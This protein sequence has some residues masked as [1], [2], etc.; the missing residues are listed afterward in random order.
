MGNRRFMLALLPAIFLNRGG[1][2][3]WSSEQFSQQYYRIHQNSEDSEL[4]RLINNNYL[5]TNEPRLS[6]YDE[7]PVNYLGFLLMEM[8]EESDRDN[9][10]EESLD[11]VFSEEIGNRRVMGAVIKTIGNFPA[12]QAEI[13]RK[14]AKKHWLKEYKKYYP[15]TEVGPCGCCTV[16]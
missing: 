5:E 10:K 11:R 4:L 9:E 6:F 8:S 15:G 1:W 2:P 7:I 12:R 16:M 3:C 13:M 14:A